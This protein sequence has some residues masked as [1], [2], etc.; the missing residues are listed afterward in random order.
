MNNFLKKNDIWCVVPVF[1]N[2]DTVK[3]VVLECSKYLSNIVVIDDGSTDININSLFFDT[4]IV[5]LNHKKNLGKGKAI[6]TAVEYIKQNNGLWVITIDADA[7]HFPSDIEKFLLAIEDTNT[8]IIGSRNFSFENIPK[9]SCFGR[10]FSNFWIKL[11]TGIDIDDTQSGFRLYPVTLFSNI[12]LKGKKYDFE[13]EVLVK[14][15]WYGVKVKVIPIKVFYPEKRENRIS[16]FRPF[17][18][19]ARISYMHCKLILKRLIFSPFKIKKIKKEF[20]KNKNNLLHPIIFLKQLLKENSTPIELGV[21]AGVG[22]FFAVLPLLSIHTL[23]ILYV[24]TR[25]HLNRVMA[26]SIQ[27]LC[28]PPFVPVLCIQ[29]GYFLLN[30]KLLLDVSFK[31]IVCQIGNRVFE[32]FLGSLI[33]APIFSIII[34][35]IVFVIARAIQK[36]ITLT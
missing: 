13:V 34:G 29:L 31:I 36:K 23:V 2:K 5:V 22:I 16:H 1:N 9:R 21:S 4:K 30:K 27:N 11:E 18:D 6:L 32:W 12:Q 7:Q 20:K 35:F 8:I 28:M 19:N 33:L 3:S 17:L 15:I 26:I 24:T 25:L 10:K 14:A